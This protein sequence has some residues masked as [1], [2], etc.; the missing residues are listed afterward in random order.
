M[1]PSGSAKYTDWAGIEACINGYLVRTRPTVLRNRAS[2]PRLR[3]WP[4]AFGIGPSKAPL[5]PPR[6]LH[7]DEIARDSLAGTAKTGTGPVKRLHQ[8]YLA[9]AEGRNVADATRSDFHRHDG[10]G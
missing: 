3:V 10:L 5:E 8:F 9:G 7:Q 4:M 6:Y 2:V 1:G